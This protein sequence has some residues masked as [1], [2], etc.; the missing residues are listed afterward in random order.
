MRRYSD[1]RLFSAGPPPQALA[2]ASKGRWA[3]FPAAYL[4][5]L[6]FSLAMTIIYVYNLNTTGKSEIWILTLMISFWV[7]TVLVL[8]LV[9]YVYLKKK[10]SNGVIERV[11]CKEELNKR[12]MGA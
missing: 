6:F 1:P 4:C 3:G 10:I 12:I 8:V 2:D 11:Y 7:L 9:I 5:M